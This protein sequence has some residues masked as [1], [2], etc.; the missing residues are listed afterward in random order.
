MARLMSV[1]LLAL[2]VAAPAVARDSSPSNWRVG[3][4]NYPN[5][6]AWQ[7]PGARLGDKGR[8]G[9]GIFGLR[10]ETARQR[11]VTVREIDA[12][13]PRRAGVGLSLKF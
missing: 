13:R 6:P 4:V 7:L 3:G 1:A 9:V 5:E 11:A 10:S 12:P 2:I 8:F